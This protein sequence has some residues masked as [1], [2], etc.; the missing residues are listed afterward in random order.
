M[1]HDPYCPDALPRDYCC[2]WVAEIRADERAAALRDAVEA[3][4]TQ[5]TDDPMLAGTNW[6]NA[7]HCAKQAIE[8]LGGEQ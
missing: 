6:N 4:E 7:L 8:A 1:T 3:V 5:W 2:D